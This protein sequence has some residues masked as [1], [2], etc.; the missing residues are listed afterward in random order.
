ML[1]LSHHHGAV[2]V[3]QYPPFGMPSHCSREHL[4][5]DI[6]ADRGQLVGVHRVV[7]PGYV[8]LDDGSIVEFGGHVMRSCPDQLHAPCVRLVIRA[9]PLKPGRNE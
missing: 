7:D 9:R 1:E 2:A 8:L 5:F 3:E 6:P 4:G